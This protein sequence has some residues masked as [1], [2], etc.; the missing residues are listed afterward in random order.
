MHVLRYTNS[1]IMRL[2]SESHYPYPDVFA[3][4]RTIRSSTVCRGLQN[5]GIWAFCSFLLLLSVPLHKFCL[6]SHCPCEVCSLLGCSCLD[7]SILL[8]SDQMPWSQTY[9]IRNCWKRWCP[10][11]F[12]QSV[13]PTQSFHSCWIFLYFVSG[14]SAFHRPIYLFHIYFHLS[15]LKDGTSYK[16]W[17][18][19]I[20]KKFNMN[21]IDTVTIIT[22]RYAKTQF[23][24]TEAERFF[25]VQVF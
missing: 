24:V 3:I 10:K 4:P 20:F 23:S 19:I 12:S 25:S 7:S 8:Q 21:G 9:Q 16:K 5:K 1:V 13:F 6:C 2:V 14:L 18:Q 11:V 17:S 15:M 22:D